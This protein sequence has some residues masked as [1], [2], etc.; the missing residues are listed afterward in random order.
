MSQYLEI[1]LVGLTSIER[2]LQLQYIQC[3]KHNKSCHCVRTN[4]DDPIPSPN[5]CKH[6]PKLSNSF[7]KRN[8]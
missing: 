4:E 2:F 8:K 1:Y 6:V 7:V 3:R 5:P